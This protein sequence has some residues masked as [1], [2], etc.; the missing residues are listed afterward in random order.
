M[1]DENRRVVFV[2]G[3]SRGIGFAIAKAFH[4]NGDAVVLNGRR[5][6]EQLRR[7]HME[8]SE[9]SS[10]PVTSVLADLSDYNACKKS[11]D[12]ACIFFNSPVSI[13]VNNAG[14]AHYGLFSDMT[15][16]EMEETLKNNLMSTLNASHMAV[17][18][19]VKAKNGCIINITSVWGISGA[20]CETVYSAAKAGVIGF[21]KALAKELGPSGIRVNAIACG[22]FETRMN[23]HLSAEEK[24]DF[25]NDIPLGRFGTPSEVGDLA[26]FLASPKASYINGQVI[27]LDGGFC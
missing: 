8:M 18:H 14:S 6:A 24:S 27:G 15:P 1:R 12:E 9:H 19:M 2:S 7:A 4:E 5:D 23:E 3:S 16:L 10:V 25:T 20:S 17:P 21:T 26:F 13:L 11:F 22:A